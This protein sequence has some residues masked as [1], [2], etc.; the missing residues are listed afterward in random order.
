FRIRLR[1]LWNPVRATRAAYRGGGRRTLPELWPSPSDHAVLDFRGTGEQRQDRRAGRVRQRHVR[2]EL[3]PGRHV[4]NEY[5]LVRG[6]IV[7]DSPDR[8]EKAVERRRFGDVLLGS[9]GERFSA[10]GGQGGRRENDHR[11]IP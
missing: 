7:T 4:R 8:G 5:E 6:Q 1:R 10:I 3:L 2:G 11:E 9:E